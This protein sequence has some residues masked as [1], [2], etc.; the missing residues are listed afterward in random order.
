MKKTVITTVSLATGLFFSVALAGDLAAGK[1]KA[2]T[3]SGCHGAP[4][5][6]NVY[7]TYKAPKIGGQSA[8]Y[9]RSALKAYADGNRSHP[10]M[11]A[12]SRSL[13][14]ADIEDIAAYLESLGK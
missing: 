4:N 8:I 5:I 12:Q 3:C 10:T 7:P 13:S 11:S 9:I 1:E 14:D 6:D 2:F